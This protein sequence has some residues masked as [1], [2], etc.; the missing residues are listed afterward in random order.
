[1]A[2]NHEIK[3]VLQSAPAFRFG[4]SIPEKEWE[5]ADVTLESAMT[6]GG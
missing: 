1:L 4:A 2:E 3:P 6:L 5:I